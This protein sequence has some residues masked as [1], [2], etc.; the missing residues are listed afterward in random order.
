MDELVR[1]P[2]SNLPSPPQVNRCVY[3]CMVDNPYRA[4]KDESKPKKCLN[5]KDACEDCRI[6]VRYVTCAVCVPY[7]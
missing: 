5:G 7:V 1:T 3:N 6:Q 4:Y 2:N